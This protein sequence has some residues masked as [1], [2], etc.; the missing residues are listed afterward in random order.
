MAGADEAAPQAEAPRPLA[1]P[2]EKPTEHKH[3]LL[4]HES[5]FSEE[6]LLLGPELLAKLGLKAGDF[7][8]ITAASAAATAG[9]HVGV[10]LVLRVAEEEA[11]EFRTSLRL[12]VLR[13]VA[14]A[15]ALTARQEVWLRPVQREAAEID[16]VELSFKDQHLSRGDIWHF[17][18]QLIE[19]N[20]TV[21]RD[22]GLHGLSAR[23][24]HDGGHFL[25]RSS[26]RSPSSSRG[27]ARRCALPP[28]RAR[29]DIPRRFSRTPPALRRCIGWRTRA[30]RSPREW[31][32]RARSSDSAPAP[33]PSCY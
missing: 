25:A 4:V 1:E 20:P 7:V 28:R 12:S 5:K 33:P 26:R 13:A 15:F 32:T 8:Q 21:R 23:S 3:T 30:C 17:R 31:S 29:R 6:E 2:S 24:T 16:W 11:K 9:Q 14:E 19:F 18:R 10:H 27:C 22:R